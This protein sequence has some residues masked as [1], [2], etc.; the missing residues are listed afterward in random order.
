MVVMSAEA[1]VKSKYRMDIGDLTPNNINQFKRLHSVLFPIRYS[2]QFYKDA[3]AAQ[4]LAKLA[5][6]SDIPVG[7]FCAKKDK[8]EGTQEY[9][10]YLMTFGVLAPYRKLGLGKLCRI[11]YNRYIDAGILD[12]EGQTAG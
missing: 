6:F 11:A 4:D 10:V 7:A 8:I 2:P 1:A 3:L 5:Y 9:A 12:Y